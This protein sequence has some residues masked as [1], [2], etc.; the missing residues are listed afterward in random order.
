MPTNFYWY[1]TQED[2]LAGPIT[3]VG[4]SLPPPYDNDYNANTLHRR[5]DEL[6]AE[7]QKRQHNRRKVNLHFSGSSSIF[8]K[9]ALDSIL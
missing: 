7:P 9:A 6:V 8:I 1:G 4:E 2:L 3:I 5:L